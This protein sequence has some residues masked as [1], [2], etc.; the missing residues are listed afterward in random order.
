MI[1]AVPLILSLESKGAGALVCYR[2]RILPFMIRVAVP[3]MYGNPNVFT[4]LTI[5][6]NE[7][8]RYHNF[9]ATIRVLMEWL[10]IC[11]HIL[12]T[13]ILLRSSEEA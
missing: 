9:D 13:S 4:K 2:A 7:H 5:R 1:Y 6:I 12:G 3:Q 10:V 11:I 8:M